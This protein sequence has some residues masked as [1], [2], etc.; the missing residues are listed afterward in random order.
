[1]CKR[2]GKCECQY[3]RN[4]QPPMLNTNVRTNRIAAICYPTVCVFAVNKQTTLA[5]TTIIHG[6]FQQWNSLMPPVKS[7][8]HRIFKPQVDQTR[9]CQS[10]QCIFLLQDY[11]RSSSKDATSS[12]CTNS[13][14]VVREEFNNHLDSVHRSPSLPPSNPTNRWVSYIWYMLFILIVVVEGASICR[15][16]YFNSR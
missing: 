9:S 8:V 5:N 7:S 1:M 13:P 3:K 14:S 12:L 16:H 2:V 10:T 11:R 4:A 15:F 6:L